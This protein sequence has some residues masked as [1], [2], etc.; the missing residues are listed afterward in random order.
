MIPY[1]EAIAR[2]NEW[3]SGLTPLFMHWSLGGVTGWCKGVLKLAGSAELHFGIDTIDG[4]D[5]L[6]VINVHRTHNPR[7]R[8]VDNRESFQFFAPQRNLSQF[9]KV[10]E[11][12]LYEDARDEVRGRVILAEVFPKETIEC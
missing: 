9:G 5:F 1:D 8:F 4:K 12:T 6:F 7:F 10:L 3:K 11:I 2:L